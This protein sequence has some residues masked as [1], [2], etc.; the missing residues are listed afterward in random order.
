MVNQR[1][2]K[3]KGNVKVS[4]PVFFD[5][6]D[7]REKM[8]YEI[9]ECFDK[10]VITERLKPSLIRLLT[11]TGKNISVRFNDSGNAGDEPASSEN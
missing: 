6:N 5:L 3:N 4:I 11:S 7:P 2:E 1:K 8:A 10:K 9:W